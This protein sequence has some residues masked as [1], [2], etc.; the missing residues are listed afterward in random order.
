VE[1]AAVVFLVMLAL[2]LI[3]TI[4]MAV[5]ANVYSAAGSVLPQSQITALTTTSRVRLFAIRAPACCR[6][7]SGEFPLL[8]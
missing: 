7:D 6:A 3:F 4:F 8:S 5:H 2:A 1:T